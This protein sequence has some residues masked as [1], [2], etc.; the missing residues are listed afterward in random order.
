LFSVL[1]LSSVRILI[2]DLSFLQSV[3][4]LC[5][6]CRVEPLILIRA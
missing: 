1:R 2:R 3:S 6:S 4:R 5:E